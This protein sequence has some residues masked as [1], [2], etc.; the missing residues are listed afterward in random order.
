MQLRRALVTDSDDV[1][2]HL[3]AKSTRDLGVPC[4][5]VARTVSEA[6]GLVQR[7]VDLVIT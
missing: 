2:R 3:L 6:C 1:W 7:G 4:V 5:H